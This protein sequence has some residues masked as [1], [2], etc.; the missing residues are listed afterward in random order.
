MGMTWDEI[1][2]EINEWREDNAKKFME[3][4]EHE[5][6]SNLTYEDL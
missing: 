1:Q 6:I 5:E 2:K 3:K 4:V